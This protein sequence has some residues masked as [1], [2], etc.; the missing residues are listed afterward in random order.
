MNYHLSVFKEE[1][2][3]EKENTLFVDRF[4]RRDCM[5]IEVIAPPSATCFEA[6]H[7]A[8]LPFSQADQ[9]FLPDLLR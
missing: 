4:A 2:E 1:K 8:E 5:S 7:L 3:K 6:G 9:S